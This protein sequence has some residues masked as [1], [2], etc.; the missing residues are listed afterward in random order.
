MLLPA[1]GQDGGLVIALRVRA[2]VEAESWNLL[3]P[4]LRVTVSGGIAESLP[5][6]ASDAHIARCDA[7]LYLAKNNGRNRIVVHA[8]SGGAPDIGPD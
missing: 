1:T 6:Q 7:A 4:E 5:E 2:A 3:A 8:A